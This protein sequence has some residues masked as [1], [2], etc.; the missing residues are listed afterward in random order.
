MFQGWVVWNEVHGATIVVRYWVGYE[1]GAFEYL[2]A[3]EA[4]NYQVGDF[5]NL[6]SADDLAAAQIAEQAC[7]AVCLDDVEH[8]RPMGRSARR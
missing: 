2:I 7:V 6:A 1:D 8:A 5:A 4:G 3:E